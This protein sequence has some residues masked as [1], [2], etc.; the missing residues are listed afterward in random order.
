V[1]KPKQ[2][3]IAVLHP[4]EMGV[5]VAAC[6]VAAGHDVLWVSY[7]RSGQT[8]SR[9]AAAR[10][11]DAGTMDEA[12]ARASVVLSICPPHAALD[13]A[14]AV[15]G[16]GG[17]YVDANAISPQTASEVAGIVEAGGA[18]YVDGGIIGPPPVT[19]GSSRLYLSGAKAGSVR[20]LFDGTKL[21]ARIVS[22]GGP[23][24][25]SAVKMAYAAWTKGSAALLLAARELGEACGVSD[26]LLGEW[27]LSQPALPGRLASAAQSAAKKGWRWIAEM[28]EIA[29]T[30]RASGLPPGFHLAAA[31]I[32]RR[33]ARAELVPHGKDD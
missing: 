25:A 30:M 17:C 23:Y 9:A 21:D 33:S 5:A 22:S 8:T 24:G 7:G 15:S 6:L 11:A 26:A 13:V 16:F 4:G 28:E 2:E 27:E 14:R 29:A 12:V 20:P 1:D 19:A 31:E 32:Y 18:T 3:A 10:L